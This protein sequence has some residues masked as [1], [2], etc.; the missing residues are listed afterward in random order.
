M[1]SPEA[2][3]DLRFR[4]LDVPLLEPFGIATGAQQLAR[5]VLVELELGDGTIGLGEAAPFPAVN[6]ETQEQVL[7]T[8][9]A[10]VAPLLGLDAFRYRMVGEAARDVLS[11]TPSAL[12]AVETALFDALGKVWRTSLWR[13]FGGADFA[14]MTDVTVPTGDVEAARQSAERARRD[15]FLTLKIKVGGD[16]LDRDARRIR[17]IHEAAP[18]TSLILDANASLTAPDALKL[19]ADAGRARGNIVLFEQ[20][21]AVDDWEGLARVEREGGVLVAADESA[22]SPADVA[23]LARS[24]SVSVVNIKVT[25]AGLIAAWEMILAARAHG[26]ELMIGGMVETELCMSTSACLAA[27]LGGFRFVDLDTPLF[28]A[29]RPLRGGF[30]QSGPRLR[31]DGIGFGHGVAFEG[32]P[33]EGRTL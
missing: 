4:P 8:L 23:G 15:G 1:T 21:T 3:V 6:G 30:E 31:V 10:A 2:I 25:K 32:A 29:E 20:P 5:N 12:A 24:R 26:L 22:R 9:P 18:D 33:H 7:S 27:G 16:D 13:F 19:L 28:L 11:N 14:L 17:A